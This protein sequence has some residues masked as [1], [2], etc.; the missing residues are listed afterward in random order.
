[1]YNFLKFKLYV[2]SHQK[3]TSYEKSNN[4][5]SIDVCFVN[6]LIINT[7]FVIKHQITMK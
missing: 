6:L 5:I 7:I 1:M 3:N 2:I 4:T